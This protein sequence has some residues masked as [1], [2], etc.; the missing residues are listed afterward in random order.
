MNVIVETLLS[1]WNTGRRTRVTPSGWVSGNAICCHHRGSNQDTR[2]RGGIIQTPAGC[3]YH[4]FNCGFSAGY[5]KGSPL[6]KNMQLLLKWL[7]VP[8]ENITKMILYAISN[9]DDH[10]SGVYKS[11]SLDLKEVDLPPL[12][13]SFVELASNNE[14]D[15]RFLSCVEYLVGRGMG[16][17]WYNWYW[18]PEKKFDNKVIIPFYNSRKIVGWT[19]RRITPGMPK[20]LSSM[21][22]GYLFNEDAQT[23]NKKYVV[24]VE[25][26]F[27]AISV[28]GVALMHNSAN[29]EQ[30]YRINS[31]NKEVILVP[32]K[33]IAGIELIDVARENNWSVS[34]PDWGD[35]V[36]DCADAVQK[37]GRIYTLHTIL[38]YRRK[39]EINLK[40]IENRIKREAKNG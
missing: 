24:V 15:D 4:C 10:V 23:F 6:S 2:A 28:D 38:H 31:L 11:L 32:D 16:L 37:Y 39:G 30:I 20:Y 7:G 18:S 9:K 21:Q 35:N 34:L 14:Y 13:K 33:D 8:D 29:E 12:A 25:G 1:Y 5:N 27:D 17:N 36:K 3:T 26:I 19:C 40:L 22:H